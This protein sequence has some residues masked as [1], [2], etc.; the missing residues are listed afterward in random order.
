MHCTED[1]LWRGIPGNYTDPNAP[2]VLA[3]V[4]KL[5]NNGNYSEAT[6]LADKDLSGDSSS[7]CSYSEAIVANDRT[8]NIQI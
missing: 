1:T 4:R 6:V 5:V 7:V 2:R 3:N 8:R